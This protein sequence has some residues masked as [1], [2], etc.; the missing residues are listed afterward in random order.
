MD[1][2]LDEDS[3]GTL[4]L[5]T[6]ITMGML[7]NSLGFLFFLGHMRVLEQKILKARKDIN[8]LFSF[9]FF[10]WREKQGSFNCTRIVASILQESS[11][12]CQS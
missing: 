8:I 11:K 9:S 3:P 4:P 2:D 7:V 12:G 5:P 10:R 6:N 1:W